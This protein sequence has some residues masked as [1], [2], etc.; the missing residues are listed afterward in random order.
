MKIVATEMR[1]S[2]ELVPSCAARLAAGLGSHHNAGGK[3][4]RRANRSLIRNGCKSASQIAKLSLAKTCEFSSHKNTVLDSI[5]ILQSG[6]G[7][8]RRQSTIASEAVALTPWRPHENPIFHEE[9][10]NVA[11]RPASNHHG[12]K[13]KG[14]SFSAFDRSLFTTEQDLHHAIDHR[15]L[16]VAAVGRRVHGAARPAAAATAAAGS[17]L[18]P[19]LEALRR[20]AATGSLPGESGGGRRRDGLRIGLA[21]EGG[22]MRGCV[23]AGMA[24]ALEHL[25][26]RD[27]FDMVRRRILFV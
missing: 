6:A 21:I 15:G 12:V 16:S 9:T 11:D 1:V 17:R 8:Y 26:L 27:C 7:S 10:Q 22:G 19:V 5:L 14:I 20:R 23:P 2:S 13:Q 24:A 25:G 4:A 3:L 18:H